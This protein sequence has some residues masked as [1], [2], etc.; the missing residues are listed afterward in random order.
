MK[1]L[2]VQLGAYLRCVSHVSEQ[3]FGDRRH[4]NHQ[5][6]N[7]SDAC[8]NKERKPSSIKPGP[9]FEP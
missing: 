6:K 7:W 1:A 2:L 4:Q 3:D 8:V 5:E 9:K